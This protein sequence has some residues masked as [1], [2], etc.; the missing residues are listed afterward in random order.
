M[1]MSASVACNC[2]V[3]GLGAPCLLEAEADLAGRLCAVADCSDE[4]LATFDEWLSNGCAHDGHRFVW[5][6][7]SNW[8]DLGIIVRVLADHAEA[9]PALGASVGGTTDTF[10][11]NM[12]DRS[13]A[14]LAELDSYD[15]LCAT[16]PQLPRWMPS[17]A[18]KLRKVFEASV[19]LDRPVV[20]D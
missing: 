5:E 13:A 1:A 6:E 12:P 4:D 16:E 3:S 17:V 11:L 9:F 7:I 2:F 10:D 15:V 18:Q 8:T 19:A 14:A 20:W